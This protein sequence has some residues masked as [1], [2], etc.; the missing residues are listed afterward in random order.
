MSA[1]RSWWWYTFKIFLSS[2][3]VEGVFDI[4]SPL[5]TVDYCWVPQGVISSTWYQFVVFFNCELFMVDKRGSELGRLLWL[6]LFFAVLWF[7][8]SISHVDRS[9]DI[10]WFA[11]IIFLIKIQS[12]FV[13]EASINSCMVPPLQ[14][15]T[16]LRIYAWMSIGVF[17]ISASKFFPTIRANCCCLGV[18]PGFLECGIC[19]FSK[20]SNWSDPQE[21]CDNSSVPM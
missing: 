21:A 5:S 19:A 3:P 7:I 11:E 12:L 2:T 8:V 15:E 9:I 20:S 4:V 6:F 1:A 16:L 18:M 17:N 13:F 10:V 14:F